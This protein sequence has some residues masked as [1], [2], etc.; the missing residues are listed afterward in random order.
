[1]SLFTRG[2]RSAFYTVAMAALMSAAF[3]SSGQA[4]VVSWVDYWFLGGP[5]PTGANYIGT[6]GVGPGYPKTFWYGGE[7]LPQTVMG[8]GPGKPNYWATSGG[9]PWIS[10]IASNAPDDCSIIAVQG[11]PA[12]PVMTLGLPDGPVQ[13]L[14]MAIFSL[15]SNGNGKT[16]VFDHPFTILSGNLTNPSGNIL[17]GVEGNGLILFPGATAALSWTMPSSEFWTGFTF[18]ALDSQAFANAP[19][20]AGVAILGIG[21]IALGAARRK[22]R[23]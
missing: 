20:P 5:H 21:L 11:G 8:C 7:G 17:A 6:A 2:G 1:M 19:E 16:F 15:G 12:K 4:A 9:A 3:P 23:A 10:A 22:R 14:V 18:G 13:N